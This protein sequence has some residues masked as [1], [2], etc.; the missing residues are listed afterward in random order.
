MP[1]SGDRFTAWIAVD[2]K[3]ARPGRQFEFHFNP[4]LRPP[5]AKAVAARALLQSRRRD[6]KRSHLSRSGTDATQNACRGETVIAMKHASTRILFNYWNEL[7]GRRPAPARSDIDPA[8][9]RHIL[10]D[11]LILAADFADEIRFRLAGTRVCALFAREIK[12]EVFKDLWSAAS[13]RQIEGPLV[14]LTDENIGTVAGVTGHAADGA[15]AELELLLLPLAHAGPARIRALGVLAPLVQPYWLG[16]Q[17]VVGLELR[18]LRHI[19]GQASE[20]AVP[21]FGHMHSG[22]GQENRRVR[23]GFLVY[24]GGRDQTPDERAG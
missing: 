10:G 11:T 15:E 2:H 22:P 12:G 6:K 20:I 17:P 14:A 8:V 19:G 7:R 16:E 3:Q 24:S 13:R 5:A 18:T 21:S 23:H 9:I 4:T 1:G